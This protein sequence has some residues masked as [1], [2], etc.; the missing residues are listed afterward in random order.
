MRVKSWMFNM[1]NVYRFTTSKAVIQIRTCGLILIRYTYMIP[2]MQMLI[3]TSYSI[4]RYVYHGENISSSKPISFSKVIKFQ[5]IQTV[6]ID[7]MRCRVILNL[8]PTFDRILSRDLPS[9][10]LSIQI[11]SLPRTM[12][13]QRR[14]LS[15]ST[16]RDYAFIQSTLSFAYP[17]W[18]CK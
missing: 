14:T 11:N 18:I 9:L 5:E 3:V 4:H 17:G 13:H 1:K 8:R 16:G 15:N 10:C 6:L 12:F 7:K 2:H